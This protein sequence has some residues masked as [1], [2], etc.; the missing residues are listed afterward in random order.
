MMLLRGTK[1]RHGGAQ[2]WRQV[3]DRTLLNVVDRTLLQLRV[4]E[5]VIAVILICFVIVES[6]VIDSLIYVDRQ[7]RH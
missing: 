2:I 1:W 5:D 6:Y 7:R 3:I 4:G